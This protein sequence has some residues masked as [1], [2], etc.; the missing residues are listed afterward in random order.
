MMNVFGIDFGT[1]NSAVVRY[2]QDGNG[3]VHLIHYADSA[4]R[5]VPS[6]VA[7]SREDGKVYVGREAKKNRLRLS[8]TCKYIPSVK[9]ELENDWEEEIGGKIWTPVKV[10]GEVFD[11]M[12]RLVWEQDGSFLKKAVVAIPIG[13]NARQ[14]KKLREAAASR[15]IEIV[16][17]VNEPTAA[18]FANYEKI[19]SCTNVVVFD[20]GGGTLDVS[21]LRHEKNKIEELATTGMPLAGNDI[22]FLLAQRLHDS[23]ARKKGKEN[24]GF[25]QMPEDR[26]DALIA[27]AEDAKIKLSDDEVAMI[28]LNRYGELGSV[29]E[30]IDQFGF[31][32]NISEFVK[33]AIQQLEK[34]IE[35]SGVGQANVDRILM[36]GGSSNLLPLQ[37]ELANRFGD[38]LYFPESTM[39]N[40]GEGAAKLASQPGN[41]H[42]NQDIGILLSDGSIYYL[43]RQGD[44]VHEW[45]KKAT[46]GITDTSQEAHLIITGSKELHDVANISV[47]TYQFLNEKIELKAKITKDLI[48]QIEAKSSFKTNAWKVW[49]QY[50]H[51]KLYYQA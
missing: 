49:W 43:L 51:L 8:K 44:N 5:P 10:A 15:G 7:I 20:W 14:R 39:W 31:S 45:E 18:F 33:K 36:V 29:H 47:P 2:Y 13:F 6:A 3:D 28:T 27:K 12:K 16:S 9:R 48:F 41:Y 11:E 38:K 4:G 35:I 34:A 37:K 50:E 1:T 17:F 42:S 32:G 26:Q 22:D 30:Q 40:V 23:I 25:D 21:V 19:C 24:I 46:F